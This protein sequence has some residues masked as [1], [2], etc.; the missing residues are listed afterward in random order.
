MLANGVVYFG[1]DEQLVAYNA[2]TGALLYLSQISASTASMASPAVVDGRIYM[3]S[4]N[5]EMLVLGL[6]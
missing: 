1:T 3:G 5:D 4:G 6:R 2:V